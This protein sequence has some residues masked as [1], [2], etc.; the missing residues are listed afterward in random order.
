M[1]PNK[2]AYLRLK[3]TG[4]YFAGFTE[5]GTAIYQIDSDYAVPC[6]QDD[7]KILTKPSMLGDY[8]DVIWVPTEQENQSL[9]NDLKDYV[10]TECSGIS[11]S[12]EQY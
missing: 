9:I 7:I 8:V 1:E 5:Q 12:G 2:F 4:E 3:T 6:Y 11:P 10:A